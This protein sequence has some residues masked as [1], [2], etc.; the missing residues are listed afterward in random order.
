[1]IAAGREP[2]DTI[3]GTIAVAT[4]A[5]TGASGAA[6]AMPRE[7]TVVCVGRSGEIAP[8]LG[9]RLNVDSGISGECLRT[10][11]ILR[12]DDASRDFHVEPE[13]CRQRG[14]QSIAVVPLRGQHGRVGVLEAFSTESYAF[15]DD[16][17]ELLGRLAGLAEAAWARGSGTENSSKAAAPPTDQESQLAN[18]SAALARVGEALTTGLYEEP[19]AERKWR[20]RAIAGLSVLFLVLVSVFVWRAWYRASIASNSTHPAPVRQVAPAAGAEVAAGVGL[21]WKPSAPR[22]ISRPNRSLVAPAANSVAEVE[23]SDVSIRQQPESPPPTDRSKVT[24]DASSDSTPSADDVPPIAASGAGQIDLGSVLS[25]S[26][27]LPK[28]GN[29]ISQGIAGGILIQKVQPTYPAEARQLRLQGNV[30]L[31][32]TITVQGQ[33]EDLKLISGP[34]LLAKAAINAVGKW[35][36]TPYLLNGQPVTKQIRITVSFLGPQ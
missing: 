25:P 22:A 7:G 8:E 9:A 24:G 15:T 28:L 2:T 27:A 31:E 18:A 11:T 1:M 19:Q 13:V 10:G 4:R 34:A 36:Y 3:L 32:A 33:V 30:I 14:L 5:L 20:H 35:R 21:T 16:H 23:I 6:I 12:C 29:P 26:P 17:M